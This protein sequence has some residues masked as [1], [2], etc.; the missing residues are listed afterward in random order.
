MRNTKKNKQIKKHKKKSTKKKAQKKVTRKRK[1]THE[2]MNQKKKK[3]IP[4]ANG[5]LTTT[6]IK[7]VFTRRPMNVFNCCCA[8]AAVFDLCLSKFTNDLA[9]S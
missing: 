4:D 5:E 8:A 7:P 2:K 6:T 1:K 3:K 9:P